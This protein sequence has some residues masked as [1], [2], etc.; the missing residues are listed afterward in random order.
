MLSGTSALHGD[1]AVSFDEDFSGMTLGDDES[2][3]TAVTTVGSDTIRSTSGL[4]T[5]WLQIM[6][7]AKAAQKIAEQ[8]YASEANFAR[9]SGPDHQ[10]ARELKRM[11]RILISSIRPRDL[12][13][14]VV[15][16]SEKLQYKILVNVNRTNEHFNQVAAWVS[17]H[18]S[19]RDKLKY[20]TLL[21]GKFMWVARKLREPNN[22]NFLGAAIAGIKSSAVGRLQPTS[23]LL[24][25]DVNK[26]LAQARDSVEL[27]VLACRVFSSLV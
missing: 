18:V 21:Q 26:L 15:S 5:T 14:H 3:I 17:N 10:I 4:S 11:D 27:F 2:T 20:K 6:A 8:F 22:N 25:P 12:V 13:R 9:R 24:P 1:P 19:C 23:D 7:N 16:S